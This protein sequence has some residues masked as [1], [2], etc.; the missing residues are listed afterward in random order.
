MTLAF[1]HW[2]NSHI[3]LVPWLQC[4]SE[5]ELWPW[6]VNTPPMPVATPMTVSR[7]VFF[8]QGFSSFA[9]ERVSE[10]TMCWKRSILV[11]PWK[12]EVER[13]CSTRRRRGWREREGRDAAR[14][15]GDVH[16]LFS[17]D[18]VCFLVKLHREWVD[19]GEQAP[20][21]WLPCGRAI[22]YRRWHFLCALYAEGRAY[23]PTPRRHSRSSVDGTQGAAAKRA[24]GEF[25]CA[26]C[27]TLSDAILS[28][29]LPSRTLQLLPALF[30]SVPSLHSSIAA[31]WLFDHHST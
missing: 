3:E 13:W 26:I 16:V 18:V 10:F 12:T 20:G 23:Q 25:L 7:F 17:A 1:R 6:S 5:V 8:V 15:P 2:H 21:Y 19:N 22:P 4:E 11:S 28:F 29:R 14:K 9:S 31:L 30:F 24:A 27:P